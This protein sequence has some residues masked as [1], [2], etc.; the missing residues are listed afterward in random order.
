MISK[1]F[2]VCKFSDYA[3][4][5]DSIWWVDSP[6]FI[7]CTICKEEFDRNKGWVVRYQPYY[8]EHLNGFFCSEPCVNMSILRDI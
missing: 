4:M 5:R 3:I 2:Q 6:F 8:G 7:T 1:Q